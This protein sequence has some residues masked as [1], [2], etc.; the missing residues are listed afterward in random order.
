MNPTY[1]TVWNRNGQAE[2]RVEG[3]VGCFGAEESET[4]KVCHR[5]C[6]VKTELNGRGRRADTLNT[7]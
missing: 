4:H 7:A 2:G 3:L 1:N 5:C 6:I